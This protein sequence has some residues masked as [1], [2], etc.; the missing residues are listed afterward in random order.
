M[1]TGTATMKPGKRKKK[2]Q[3][4]PYLF[5]LPNF[6]IFSIFIIVPTIM[7]FIY[8]FNEYDGL[9]PMEFIGIEN[10]MN[11]FTNEMF[12]SAL[13]KTALYAAIVV[14]LIYCLSLAVAMLL[15]QEIRLKGFFRAIFYWPTMISF[16][17]VGLTWK[18]I[19]GDLGILN[20]ILSLFG[21]DTIPF[22]SSPFYANLSV[23]IATVWSR[24]GFFMVIFMAGL[25]AIPGDYYEAAHLDGAS[26]LRSF[27]SITLPLLKPTSFLVIMISLIDAFKSYPLMFALTG[28]GPGRETTF[29]V[30]YIYEVGFMRQELGVASAMS[31]VLFVIISLFT[32]L[33]FR[34]AKGG[35]V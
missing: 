16:I 25:Q 15:I 24:L 4:T 10:Y 8:S 21:A 17:I 3:L 23:I 12:W 9:N 28:G 6:L 27:W 5:V 14:P 22:L 32:I 2:F 13:G 7:G 33:Q 11:V 31:V 18:W 19:F 26:K 34:L 35:A 30:Q 20:Y 29:I 1:A